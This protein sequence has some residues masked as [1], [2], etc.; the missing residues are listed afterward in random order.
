MRKK[1][2]KGCEPRCFQDEVRKGTEVGW[3][4]KVTKTETFSAK[5]SLGKLAARTLNPEKEMYSQAGSQGQ[6]DINR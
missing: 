1:K 5:I 6:G 4:R 2:K 3:G